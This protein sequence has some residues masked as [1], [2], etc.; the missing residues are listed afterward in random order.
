MSSSEKPMSE[1]FLEGREEVRNAERRVAD[2]RVQAVEA[3]HEVRI[4]R[5]LAAFSNMRREI[6]AALNKV[7]AQINQS[8]STEE[9]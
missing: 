1:M 7:E 2:A 5:L 3:R 6:E 8:T 4:T 9:K